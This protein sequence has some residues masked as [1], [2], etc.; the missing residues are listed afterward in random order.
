MC[1]VHHTCPPAEPSTLVT[2]FTAR[3]R[4]V[5]F[6]PSV[7]LEMALDSIARYIHSCLMYTLLTFLKHINNS[8]IGCNVGGKMINVLAYDDVLG[9]TKCRAGAITKYC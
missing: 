7:V 6:Q 1:L 4:N 8:G 5:I 2:D 3:N 9:V